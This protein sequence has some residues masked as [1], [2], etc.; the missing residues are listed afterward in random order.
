MRAFLLHQPGVVECCPLSLVEL[1]DPTPGPGQVRVLVHACAACRTD[2]HIVEGELPLPCPGITP[3]HQ[4]VGVVDAVGA[5]VAPSLL[6]QRVGVAW[7]HATCGHCRFC[8]SQRENLCEHARFT[9]YTEAGGFAER[10]LARADFVYPL[11]PELDDVRAAPLLCA[12]IIGYRA[13]ARTALAS[14]P[15]A[16]LGIYGFG[17]AG[18]IAIQL[19]RARGADV[20]VATRERVHRELAE[21]LGARWVGGTSDAPPVALDAALIFAPAG[22]LVPV[23]LT[24]LD[25]GARLVLGGIHMSDIPRFPYAS[26]YGERELCSVANNTRADGHAFLREAARVGVQTHVQTFAFEDVPRA[27]IELKRGIPGAAVVRVRA[28]AQ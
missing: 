19:A 15:G 28:S 7:L 24:H 21:Q 10:M 5:Q 6:G 13:L 16:R 1:P 23:A 12:G 22:E 4:V 8:L 25:K 17:A 20:Y 9:G 26:L 3:G 2:L 11:P 14:W 18:H 27:L